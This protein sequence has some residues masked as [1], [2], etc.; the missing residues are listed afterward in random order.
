[1]DL[2]PGRVS[3]VRDLYAT[4]VFTYVN[5]RARVCSVLCLYVYSNT[6]IRNEE[7]TPSYVYE[8]TPVDVCVYTC[9]QT[10]TYVSGL[11]PYTSGH[12]FEGRSFVDS[13]PRVRLHVYGR[14][15][16]LSTPPSEKNGLLRFSQ[17]HPVGEES[18]RPSTVTSTDTRPSVHISFR[19]SR[20]G[21]G[22]VCV[23]PRPW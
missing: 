18:G 20:S 6:C 5:V 15:R 13:R 9:K 17:G 4:Y 14:R 7:R 23:R 2:V 10:H 16:I 1:M 22:R 11:S 8:G 3:S 21:R 19:P 12:E